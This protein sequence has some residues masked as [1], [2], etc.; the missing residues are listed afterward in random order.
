[1]V[2]AA[3]AVVV[4]TVAHTVAEEQYIIKGLGTHLI[5]SQDRG[6]EQ[7][8]TR[9]RVPHQEGMV[10]IVVDEA[11]VGMVDIVEVDIVEV[12]TAVEE[13]TVAE[14]LEVD[15]ANQCGG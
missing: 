10:G 8:A 13:D 4:A 1:M 9:M 5:K 7:V 14:V 6:V 12:D 15:T 3:L 2:R 11:E